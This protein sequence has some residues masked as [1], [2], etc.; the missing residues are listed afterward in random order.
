LFVEYIFIGVNI[1]NN[2]NSNQE[3]P[4]HYAVTRGMIDNVQI[5]LENGADVNIVNK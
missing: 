5:L 1:N 4:L 3:T 2:G